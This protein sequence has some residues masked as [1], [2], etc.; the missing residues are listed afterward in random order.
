VQI[1]GGGFGISWNGDVDLSENE[2]WNEGK[3]L[4]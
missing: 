4:N 3:E 1:D 2:L